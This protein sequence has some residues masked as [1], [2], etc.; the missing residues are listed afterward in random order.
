MKLANNVKE[1]IKDKNQTLALILKNGEFPEGLN[2]HTQDSDFVQVATWNYSKGKKSSTHAHKFYSR[3]SSRTQ[4]VIYVKKGKCRVKIYG[5]DDKLLKEII[6]KEGDLIIIF[7]GGHAFEVLEDGTQVLEVKNG[8]Y[9][10]IEKDKRDI[11]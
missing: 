5:E 10:G 3:T 6:L 9:P 11:K 1:I 2:F 7:G 8:P 4:E